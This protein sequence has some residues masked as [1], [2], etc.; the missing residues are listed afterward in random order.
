MN[1][2]VTSTVQLNNGVAM[3]WF[4]LGTFLSEKGLPTQNAVR[5]ALEAGYRHI[6][7]AAIYRNEED[8]GLALRQSGIDRREV[9][10]VTK[11]WN[12]DHGYDST[13]R[14][15]DAS[16]KRLGTDYVDL[17]L[18]HWP[19]SKLRGQ[20]WKALVKLLEED[21][22]RAIGVSNYTVRHL[23]ELLAEST[24]VPAVNQVE[25]NPFLYRKELL[26]YCRAK[27]IQLEGYC[28]LARARKL[29]D[30][31][32]VAVAAKYGKTP[33][34]VAIRWA[35]QREVVT[36]PKSIHQER[37]LENA[38]VFD[39]DMAAEDMETLDAL[40]ENYWVIS[41]AWNPETSPNWA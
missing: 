23:E 12:E 24:V 3:P 18:I 39:F 28:P 17:Y 2:T 38:D 36:I 7:T 5:W 41:P 10:I 16:L 21:R 27:G 31:R 4:G 8:V 32:L 1:L 22:C 19:V 11:V 30:P 34:Q 37:I 9:F 13:L 14:A 33:A 20:T 40:N 26:D 6:D 35:L 15:Y 25:F 29:D